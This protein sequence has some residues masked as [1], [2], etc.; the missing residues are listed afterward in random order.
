MYVASLYAVN[1]L[2]FAVNLLYNK[3]MHILQKSAFGRKH[4]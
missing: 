3:I 2:D 4:T 1:L